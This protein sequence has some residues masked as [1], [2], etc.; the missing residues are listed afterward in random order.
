MGRY[1]DMAIGRT[2]LYLAP[3]FCMIFDSRFLDDKL[4]PIF[5]F[6]NVALP[7]NQRNAAV[8]I[9]SHLSGPFSITL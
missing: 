3:R 5:I 9:D 8:T 4:R 6:L 7:G 1:V 2:F